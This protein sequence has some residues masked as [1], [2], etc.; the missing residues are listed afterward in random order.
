MSCN[1]YLPEDDDAVEESKSI[2]P[3]ALNPSPLLRSIEFKLMVTGSEFRLRLCA[4]AVCLRVIN[5][6]DH[7]GYIHK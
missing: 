7:K 6:G 3:Q 4:A 2:Q 5:R 1:I